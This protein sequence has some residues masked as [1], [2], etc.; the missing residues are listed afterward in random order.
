MEEKINADYNA[1]DIEK[2]SPITSKVQ[3]TINDSYAMNEKI[4]EERT[5]MQKFW[6][7]A[8]SQE[9]CCDMFSTGSLGP[10]MYGLNTRN[11]YLVILFMNLLCTIPPAYFT[12]FGP[13]LGFRQMVLSRYSFGYFSVILPVI[14]NLIGMLC[15]NTMDSIL[16][17]QTL[18]SITDGKLSWIVGIS[19]VTVISLFISFMGYSVLHW[20]KWFT[21][22]PV[23]IT[24]IIAIGV[25]GHHLSNPVTFEPATT[26]MVLSF[27]SV[28][29]QCLGAAV[30]AC[31][32]NVPSWQAGY[33]D[34]SVGGLLAAMLSPVGNFGKFLMVLLSLSFMGNIAAT[35]YS[36]SLNFQD[37]TYAIILT[38]EHFLFR[39]G[40][41]ANYDPSIWN[42]PRKLPVGLAAF[43]SLAAGFCIAIPAMDQLWYVGPIAKK[44][45]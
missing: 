19:I 6:V 39:K 14:F 26:P 35:F 36:I 27:A 42:N 3:E 11:S 2:S 20:Y 15:F 24:F 12:T 37:Y 40:D 34:G 44:T 32:P 38:I 22:I 43:L 21:W 9:V 7:M 18:A 13:K 45:Q 1:G 25:G 30:G 29:L 10:L 41:T 23:I 33:E 31:I 5:W 4:G 28:L 17:G 16:G 8:S